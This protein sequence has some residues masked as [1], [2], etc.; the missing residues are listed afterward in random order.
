MATAAN[1][2][3]V[4]VNTTTNNNS[5]C[6]LA[7]VRASNE[8]LRLEIKRLKKDL[9]AERR[10]IKELFVLHQGDLRQ[11][12][13]QEQDRAQALLCDLKTKLNHERI[14]EL[15]KQKEKL[16]KDHEFEVTKLSK[17]HQENVWRLSTDK[18][19]EKEQ[20]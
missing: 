19:K 1:G 4:A 2:T 6:M 20:I 18:K 8:K 3:Q 15:N 17:E 13:A 5:E 7:G 16:T 12:R 14:A 9:E 10:N 11:V